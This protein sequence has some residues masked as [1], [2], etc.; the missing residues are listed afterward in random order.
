MTSFR[1]TEREG[2]ADTMNYGDRRPKFRF[3]PSL[4]SGPPTKYKH[5]FSILSVKIETQ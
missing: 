1:D 2:D 5:D 3:L 4:W